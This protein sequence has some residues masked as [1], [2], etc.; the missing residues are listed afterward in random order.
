[1]IGRIIDFN[2]VHQIY[3]LSYDDIL[4]PNLKA[5]LEYISLGLVVEGN[6]PAVME[7]LLHHAHNEIIPVQNKWIYKYYPVEI[8]ARTYL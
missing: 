6:G 5:L 3:V 1:M 8:A 2:R 4:A 7:A